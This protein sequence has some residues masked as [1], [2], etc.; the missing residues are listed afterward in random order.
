MKNL[1]CA[2]ACV[3]QAVAFAANTWYVDDDWYGKGGD[4]SAE[5]PYGTIQDAVSASTTLAGDTILVA[6][7]TYAHGSANAYG[8]NWRVHVSKADLTIRATGGRDVTFIVGQA[9]DDPSTPY[10]AGAIAGV[11][12][13]GV[14]GFILD[15]FTVSDCHMLSD[16]IGSAVYG[17]SRA[18]THIFSCAFVRNYS[19]SGCVWQAS[20]HRSLV[21]GNF[22]HSSAD[23]PSSGIR[24]CDAEHCLLIGNDCYAAYSGSIYN[25]TILGNKRVCVGYPSRGMNLIIGKQTDSNTFY[26]WS[27]TPFCLSNSVTTATQGSTFSG[28][29]V[30]GENA[31][32][33]NLDEVF[34]APA[35]GDYGVLEGSPAALRGDP[36]HLTDWLAL[37]QGRDPADDPGRYSTFRDY[38]GNPVD[39]T[40]AR[41]NA[42]AIQNVLV[43]KGQ[44]G[45]VRFSGSG[46]AVDG[47]AVAPLFASF[48]WAYTIPTQ[49]CLTATSP[50]TAPLSCVKDSVLGRYRFAGF[51][52]RIVVSTAAAGT[53]QTLAVEVAD[54]IHYVNP[55]PLVGSDGYDG[56]SPT[57]VPGTLQ[58]PWRTL[59]MAGT[60][61]TYAASGRHVVYCAA[62]TYDSGS[63]SQSRVL[64]S[65]SNIHFVGAGA[66][67][68]IV[69]GKEA[70]EEDPDY[71]GTGLGSGALRCVYAENPTAG[72]TGFTFTGGRTVTTVNWP[73]GYAAFAYCGTVGFTESVITGNYGRYYV[74]CGDVTLERCLFSGN[75][76]VGGGSYSKTPVLVDEITV[77]DAG[78]QLVRED[79]GGAMVFSASP[80]VARPISGVTVNGRVRLFDGSGRVVIPYSELVGGGT[81]TIA[82]YDSCTWYVNAGG[83]HGEWA[84]GDDANTGFSRLSPKLTL[85]EGASKAVAGDTVL[86]AAGTYD[87]GVVEFKRNW[88]ATTLQSTNLLARV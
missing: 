72:F 27:G 15:G 62:G 43:A 58:G 37:P 42:G 51:D 74:A 20:V 41:I 12:A 7:G 16:A 53:E 46:F 40:A 75:G 39:V 81:V 33:V 35:F 17:K 5:R 73:V 79:A 85:K 65:T 34:V 25:C 83:A 76:A 1:V 66:G 67:E 56:T 38:N 9:P 63:A 69:V 80:D 36:K 60:N 44:M 54:D 50:E 82:P 55:D 23:N 86:A 30:E 57:N 61:K 2:V 26:N 52:G 59:V 18:A 64:V 78:G 71:P 8:H 11:C 70:D 22:V 24:D 13:Y 14:D 68:S 84:A 48:N 29:Y 49:W 32:E 3:A 88:W 31:Y 4:G 47:R 87:Q 10:G 77:D 45:L 19:K 6:P 28:S 21:K